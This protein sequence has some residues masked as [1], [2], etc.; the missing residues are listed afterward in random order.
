LRLFGLRLGAVIGGIIILLLIGS[1]GIGRYRAYLVSLTPTPTPTLTATPTFTATATFTPTATATEMPTSTP[2]LTPTP[3]TAFAL[4][5]VFARSGCYE[6]FTA[7]GRIPSGGII[8]FL[9][10]ERRFDDFN[11]E[12]VFVEYQREDGVV[13]GWVL[14]ADVGAEPPP[15]ATPEP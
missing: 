5:E 3:L 9:P 2:T 10:A 7:A 1:W 15:T 6:G 12:C 13:I 11:R 8:R 14:L 4:R